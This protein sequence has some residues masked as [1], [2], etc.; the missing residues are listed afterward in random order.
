MQF[1]FGTKKHRVRNFL[2]CL[3][4]AC[5]AYFSAVWVNMGS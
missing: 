5:I 2:I 3:G 1:L 4:M